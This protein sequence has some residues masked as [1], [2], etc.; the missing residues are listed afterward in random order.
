MCLCLSPTNNFLN[1]D[2]SSE[3]PNH[4]RNN[5]GITSFSQHLT[6]YPKRG[7]VSKSNSSAGGGDGTHGHRLILVFP[8]LS[9]HS[10][11]FST[12]KWEI[13]VSVIH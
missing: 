8:Q 2:P 9:H 1:F 10:S 12:V 5:K 11:L 6:C 13:K 7:P 4:P 3:E